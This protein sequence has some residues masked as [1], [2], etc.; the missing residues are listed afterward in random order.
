[1]GEPKSQPRREPDCRTLQTAGVPFGSLTGPL[2]NTTVT[3]NGEARLNGALTP[4]PGNSFRLSVENMHLTSTTAGS[5]QGSL[6]QVWSN[7]D[8][9]GT[10]VGRDREIANLTRSTGGP[11]SLALTPPNGGPTAHDLIRLMR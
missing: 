3:E 11:T 7:T 4:L 8:F 9:S 2:T 5:I 10:M 6:E 1:M